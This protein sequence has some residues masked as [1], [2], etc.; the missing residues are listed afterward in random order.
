MELVAPET[1]LGMMVAL[2]SPEDDASSASEDGDEA[3]GGLS[4]SA[5]AAPVAPP[6]WPYEEPDDPNL[7][8]AALG[9]ACALQGLMRNWFSPGPAPR[10]LDEGRFPLC[11]RGAPLASFVWGSAPDILHDQHDL[12]VPPLGTVRCADCPRRRFRAT[13]G[14]CR[15]C[16]CG[17]S[18]GSWW[19]D[20][21]CGSRIWCLR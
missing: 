15:I 1:G 17:S 8:H 21:E 5:P 14:K 9:T 16:R 19:S 6:W 12:T 2:S 13:D 11:A 3:D 20:W 4:L 10:L 18:C 7:H